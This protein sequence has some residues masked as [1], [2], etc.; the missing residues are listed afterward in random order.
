MERSKTKI[1][2]AIYSFSI[3][4]MG[5]IAIAG[6][7][8]VLGARFGPLGYD[9]SQLMAIP[10]IPIIIVTIV[11]GKLQ[12]YIPIKV[13]VIIGILCFLIGG[14]V[15]AF[16]TSFPAIL[17]LRAV[18]GVGVGLAQTLSSALVG[19]HF[20]GAERQKVMGI[21]TS[22][23]MIGA[24]V[25]MFASGYLAKISWEATF[26]VHILAVLSLIVVLVCLPMDKPMRK[27][28]GQ[29]STEKVKLTGGAYGWAI[30]LTI[31]FLAGM[32]LAQF[33][34]IFMQEHGIGGAA[35]SGNATLLFALGGFL[36]GLIYGKLNSALKNFTLTFGCVLG[37]IAFLFIAFAK[38]VALAYLGSFIYGGCISVVMAFVMTATAMS[39]KPNAIPLA[40]ALTTCGQNLGSYFC[41]IIARWGAGLFG[42]DITKN[43]FLFGCLI[44]AIIGIVYIFWG[45]AETKR[46][47]GQERVSVT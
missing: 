26:W 20:E 7:M 21:Q 13:L 16:L 29:A 44:F 35:E 41:P 14:I 10:S 32:I 4:M 30:T 6:G 39:V 1:K 17:V 42:S 28:G 8:G 12:E 15:P 45:I 47:K 46:Q 38:S 22:A 23:Q 24:A 18:F 37:I 36:T 3:L 2:L 9:V 19:M 27:S 43:V 31:F 25:M 11:A 5:V 40:I 34:A 33:V